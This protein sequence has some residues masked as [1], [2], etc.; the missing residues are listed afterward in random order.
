M[1]G[2]PNSSSQCLSQTIGKQSEVDIL[3]FAIS[4]LFKEN[5]NKNAPSDESQ[6]T[7]ILHSACGQFPAVT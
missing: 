2:I 1:G 5:K 6:L 4:K 7:S 3:L